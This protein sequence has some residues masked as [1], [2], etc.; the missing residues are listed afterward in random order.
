MKILCACLF[1][2]VALC[3]RAEEPH[4]AEII[5]AVSESVANLKAA[6][7][8]AVPMAFWDFDGTIIK[9]DI[10]DGFRERDGRGYRGLVDASI[11]AG[12]TSVYR[13]EQGVRQWRADYRRMAEI[14]AW[15][16]QA[17]D[18]QMYAGTRASDLE[19]FC[20][21]WIRDEGI[22]G[23]YFASSMAIWRALERLGV[24]NCVVSANIEPLIRGTAPSL[25]IPRERVRASRAEIVGGRVTTKV[26]Y[27]IPHGPGKVVAV[28]EV[29]LARPHGVA[30]AGFGNSY[31]TDG[32]FLRY[33][34]SQPLPGG[35]KPISVM[36]NGGA[37]PKEYKG[38]FK[39]VDQQEICGERT[40]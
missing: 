37:E 8:E 26:L 6:D 13:E 19:A 15:F 11:L 10:G 21:K 30:V 23:W 40:P 5:A 22:A 1:A 25:G 29:V 4:V 18:V 20:S 28:R 2:L 39:L 7:P 38:L 24:E 17:F 27:P 16:S 12:L 34:C 33:I 35:V 14:G 9:G 3:A 31:R 36:I 32:N